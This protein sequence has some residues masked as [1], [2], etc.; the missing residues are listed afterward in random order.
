MREIQGDHGVSLEQKLLW[1]QPI[2]SSVSRICSDADNAL[3]EQLAASEMIANWA[4][5]IAEISLS[6]HQRRNRQDL[7]QPR[8]VDG[9]RL[10]ISKPYSVSS[11]FCLGLAAAAFWGLVDRLRERWSMPP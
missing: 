8:V 1:R 2:I 9:V 4:G 5:P 3:R 7:Q 6:V 11:A 10:E